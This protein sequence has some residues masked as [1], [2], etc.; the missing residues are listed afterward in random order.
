MAVITGTGHVRQGSGTPAIKTMQSVRLGQQIFI[1]LGAIVIYF[2]VRHLTEGSVSSAVANAA[3]VVD[4]E[5]ALGLHHEQWLQDTFASSSRVSTVFN[6]IYI[7]G[8]WPVIAVTLIWLARKHQVIYL[9]TR[10]AMIMSGAIG[11]V[12]FATFPV[13]PPRL[14]HLDMVDTVTVSSHAYRVLQPPMFTNQYAAVPSLHVGWDLLMGIAI[15]IAARRLWVKV[16]GVLMPIAMTIAV[17][18]TAN[19]YIVDAI[20][21]AALTTSCWFAVRWWARRRELRLQVATT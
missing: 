8:H 11:M 3:R 10:N 19:H 16:I 2:G 14:A 13:A 9:R 21:G 6:W 20:A 1:L 5:R 17:V 12:I 4:L 7:W 18:L 15:A